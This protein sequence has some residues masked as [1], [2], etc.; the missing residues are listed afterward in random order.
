MLTLNIQLRHTDFRHSSRAVL[1]FL[2]E[3]TWTL[4][5]ISNNNVTKYTHNFIQSTDVSDGRD[6]S[7]Y[8]YRFVDIQ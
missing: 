8:S 2:R 5:G 7:S 4:D 6:T 1:L 3:H